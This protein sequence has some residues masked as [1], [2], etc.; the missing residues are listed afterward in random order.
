MGSGSDSHKT[1]MNKIKLH[2]V[3]LFLFIIASLGCCSQVEGKLDIPVEFTK[4]IKLYRK[5]YKPGTIEFTERFSIFK[6]HFIL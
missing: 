6:V 3:Q 5:P 4:F 2:C 1:N